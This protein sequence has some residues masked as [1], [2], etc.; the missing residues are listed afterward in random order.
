MSAK[1]TLGTDLEKYPTDEDNANG[2]SE[3]IYD[4]FDSLQDQRLLRKVD[5]RW[6][7][8]SPY[9]LVSADSHLTRLLPI[10]TLLFLL[11][12][13]DRFVYFFSCLY[14]YTYLYLLQHKHRKR[15]VSAHSLLYDIT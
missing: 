6:H 3:I 13:L 4:E 9:Y 2:I 5:L 10:L 12:F 11:S 14:A 7:F 8:K 1:H 15:Q